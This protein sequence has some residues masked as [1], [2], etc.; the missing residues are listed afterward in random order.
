M[1]GEAPE[2]CELS[3]RVVVRVGRGGRT[4]ESGGDGRV[5]ICWM[6]GLLGCPSSQSR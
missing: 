2:G 3:E 5:H 6:M 1:S 4:G